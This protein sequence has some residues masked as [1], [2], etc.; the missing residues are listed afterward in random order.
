MLTIELLVKKTNINWRDISEFS[1]IAEYHLNHACELPFEEFNRIANRFQVTNK[2]IFFS[3]IE[4]YISLEKL[5]LEFTNKQYNHFIY[6]YV[7]PY[8]ALEDNV[9]LQI[10]LLTD[11]LELTTVN[12]VQKIKLF[13]DMSVFKILFKSYQEI[14]L[15]ERD[16]SDQIVPEDMKGYGRLL[17]KYVSEYANPLIP[18]PTNKWIKLEVF[19]SAFRCAAQQGALCDMIALSLL[20]P[21][22]N[23]T[24]SVSAMTALHF[25]AVYANKEGNRDC[26]DWLRADSTIKPDLRNII[27]LTAEDLLLTFNVNDE[28]CDAEI[29]ASPEIQTI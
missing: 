19:G 10:E 26:Y 23:A 3:Q 12:G 24:S 21:D 22:I 16:V 8:D 4:K 17:R 9:E 28:T 13:D 20:I 25:A 7:N 27:G 2:I 6:W 18:L 5:S 15:K 14:L 29:V 11:L 1:L